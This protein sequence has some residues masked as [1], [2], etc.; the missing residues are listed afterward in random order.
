MASA[1]SEPHSRPAAPRSAAGIPNLGL[2]ENKIEAYGDTNHTG[3]VSPQSNYARQTDDI[4]ARTQ[5]YLQERLAN[6][7][8]IKGKPALVLDIDDTSL[9]TL[10]YEVSIGSRPWDH[11]VLDHG[12]AGESAQP[13]RSQPG[14]CRYASTSWLTSATSSAT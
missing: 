10:G 4:T 2:V 12:Q 5:R 1:H 11:G 13:H 3:V 6:P 14:R 7:R 9:I 8:H